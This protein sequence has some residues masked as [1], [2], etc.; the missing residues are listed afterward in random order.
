MSKEFIT[1]KEA[2]DYLGVT[3][4]YLYKMVHL[5]KIPYYKPRGKM[6]YFSVAELDQ[7]IGSSRVA[8][9]EEIIINSLKK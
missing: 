4:P 1:S 7:Q 8:T 9:D 6:I 5:K 3:L 2:A